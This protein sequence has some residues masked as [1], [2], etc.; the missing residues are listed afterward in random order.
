MHLKFY[1]ATLL[2]AI[3]AVHAGQAPPWLGFG[4]NAQHTAQSGVS[5]Q[6]LKT[7]LW[8]TPVDLKPQYTSGGFLS[9]H[10]A[11]PMAT[12]ANTIIVPVKTGATQGFSIQGLNGRDGSQR[13]SHTT[14]F[15]LAPYNGLWTPSF[16]AVLTLQN[17]LYFAGSGGTVY[18][19]DNPDASGA[20][21]TGQFC[22]YG[23][24]NYQANQSYCD[25]NVFICTPLTSDSSGNI[26]FGFV[27]S[28]GG[29]IA[30]LVSGIARVAPNGTGS[31]ASAQ[32]AGS[33]DS[34]ITKP[35][36]N[37]APALSNDGQQV[38]IAVS[39]SASIYAIGRLAVLNAANLAPVSS[40]QLLDQHGTRAYLPDNG[41]ACPTIGPD[42][43]VYQGVLENP[44]DY[45]HQR[46]W[47][48]HFSGDLSVQKPTG[49]FGWDDTPSMVP[50]AMVPSYTGTSTY[51]IVTKYN[52]Y[53]FAGGDGT[54][55]LAVLDPH[56]TQIDPISGTTIMKEILTILGPT[57]DPNYIKKYPNAVKDWCIDS[58][59][60]DPAHGAVYAGNE[61]GKLY[62]WDLATNTFQESIVLTSGLGEAYT[63]TL[64]GPD[65][66]V[67]AINNATLFAV[68][69]APPQFVNG[70]AT[71]STDIN[72]SYSFTYWSSGLPAPT[73]AVTSGKLPDGLTLDPNSGTISGTS[74][75]TGTFSGV[76]TATNSSGSAT[77]SFSIT[78]F[79][80]LSIVPAAA[81]NGTAAAAYSFVATVND[82]TK[83]YTVLNVT[84]FDA[85]ATGLTAPTTN[86][87]NGT[88]TLSGTPTGSGVARFTVN[89]T[90]GSGSSI[91]RSYTVIINPGR[92]LLPAGQVG[93]AYSQSLPGKDGLPA[94]T[95]TF[96]LASGSQLTPGLALSSDGTV[97]GTSSAT[98][99][100]SFNANATDSTPP[101]SGGPVT[102][103]LV[104]STPFTAPTLSFNSTLP[105]GNL[106][107]PYSQQLTAGG[108][109]APYSFKLSSGALPPGLTL[110]N[111][112]SISGTPGSEG[113]FKFAVTAS[114][115]TTGGGPY[116]VTSNF[117]VLIDCVP[118][119]VSS[120]FMTAQL[121]PGLTTQV[122]ETG[123]F[124][125]FSTATDPP[126][127]IIS[128]N[129]GDGSPALIGATVQH[130]YATAGT[131]AVSVTATNPRT[132]SASTQ[133]L[134][135]QVSEGTAAL[136]GTLPLQLQN[137]TI[138]LASHAS[139]IALHATIDLLDGDQIN[140]STM[141]VAVNGVTRVFTLGARGQGRSTNSIAR[142]SFK[143]TNGTIAAQKAP[144]TVTISG[145]DIPAE[146]S[147][148]VAVNGAGQPVK[149][150]IQVMLNGRILSSIA[151]LQFK[152]MA[153]TSV[154]RVNSN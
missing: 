129:F 60:V 53:A 154:A 92:I 23:M 113:D 4:G 153:K 119:F 71:P 24:N 51:L 9:V 46:G 132:G 145:A 36:Y 30:G 78:V 133:T 68:G 41:T 3:S 66:A 143:M 108:G 121:A 117:D 17:R 67:Y 137:G 59:A 35:V 151:P 127:A 48:L 16:P 2:L 95:Y 54:N 38:Y 31:F 75:K 29:P 5:A 26:Y 34:S 118:T 58:V 77:Q 6:P 146:L 89:V 56:D 101:S 43:D 52:N 55:K 149:A 97:S 50:A 20:A 94:G 80:G 122:T 39:N 12:S 98:G 65:G 125:Q 148:G 79:Q 44:I 84:G 81:P 40:V 1:S 72:T 8:Q 140:G 91:S 109:T 32:S 138:M 150:V 42:G 110:G 96:A 57:P 136:A 47:L 152:K 13:W 73:F 88:V 107:T 27:V 61:D 87:G 70:P 128:W 104:L 37:C 120:P 19:I 115:S 124:V 11:E 112:G 123:L 102:Y 83:P 69:S 64:I 10:Y 114:D 141:T 100:Y 139:R 18:Y 25:A 106:G 63:P 135:I 111:D 105:G 142:L 45:N 82:G 134:S 130:L 21:V 131:Y 90:D 33:G 147:S 7:V 14:N 15:V 103:T 85:G 49:A 126:D 144:L 99:T 76:V 62:H 86:T 93:V 28:S 116:S 74:T 22:F